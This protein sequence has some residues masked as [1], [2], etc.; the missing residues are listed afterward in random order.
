MSAGL[1]CGSRVIV[2]VTVPRSSRSRA[3]ARMRKS[4][5]SPCRG[6]DETQQVERKAWMALEFLLDVPDLGIAHRQRKQPQQRQVGG[7]GPL[8]RQQLR[9]REVEA[10]EKVDTERLRVLELLARLHLLGDD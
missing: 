3:S 10:L 5:S 4:A 9:A 8:G 2:F 1:R 7:L 6:I